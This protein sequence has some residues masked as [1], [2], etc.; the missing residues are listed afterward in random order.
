MEQIIPNQTNLKSII[1]GVGEYLY[2]VSATEGVHR[3]KI[4]SV[5]VLMDK[6]QLTVDIP[7]TTWFPKTYTFKLL[8]ENGSFITVPF[9]THYELNLYYSMDI[10]VVR[11]FSANLNRMLSQRLETYDLINV[12]EIE[13]TVNQN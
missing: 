10:Q 13:R 11:E 5:N 9:G 7:E 6:H 4:R 3:F 1:S 2:I 8:P 12:T